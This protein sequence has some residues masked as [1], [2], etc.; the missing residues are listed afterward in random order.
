MESD[1][2]FSAIQRT[3]DI[4]GCQVAHRSL[5]E[6]AWRR[7][8]VSVRVQRDEYAISSICSHY[9][10]LQG[11][12][13]AVHVP[14]E[15]LSTKAIDEG[16]ECHRR[17]RRY[18]G[19]SVADDSRCQLSRLWSRRYSGKPKLPKADSA[20]TPYIQLDRCD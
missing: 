14:N 12:S 17:I 13:V 6:S 19:P 5:R 20:R 4:H 8:S 2:G 16:S 15:F 1:H 7:V 9:G 3:A 18:T 10:Y 11:L